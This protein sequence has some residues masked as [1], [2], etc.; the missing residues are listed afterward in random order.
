MLPLKNVDLDSALNI[1]MIN[2]FTPMLG[3]TFEVLT[4]G[5]RIG[6]STTVNGLEVGGGGP[7]FELTHGSTELTLV[8][9][10]P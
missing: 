7:I 2:G 4:F 3:E 5:S 1:S 9:V 6:D 8:V 10:E